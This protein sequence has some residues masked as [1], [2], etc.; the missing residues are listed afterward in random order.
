MSDRR[1]PDFS[2]RNFWGWGLT[3]EI[4]APDHIAGLTDTVAGR[5]GVPIER[6]Q[7]R[8]PP[9]LADIRLAKPKISPPPAL[10]DCLTADAH[11]RAGHCYGKSFRDVIRALDRRFDCAPDLVAVP[12]DEGQLQEILH[13]CESGDIAVI[14][15]GGGSSVS[16]GVEAR[17][18]TTDY[19]GVVS[20]DLRCLDRVLEVDTHSRTA[21]IQGGI[22]GPALEEVLRPQGLT[23][24]HYP[25]SFE[26]STL[27]GW[28]ATRS[29]GHYATR[30]THIDEFVQ[31][32]RMVSPAGVVQTRRLPGSGAG[33]DPNRF[34]I[35][36][37][38]TAGIITEA[39]MRL[40]HRPDSR[41]SSVISF[42][43]EQAAVEACRL[44]SQSGLEPANLRLI[45]A[46]E[47]RNTGVNDGSAHCL[48]LGFEGKQRNLA[49]LLAEGL[50]I[51][52]AQGG[53]FSPPKQGNKQAKRPESADV[54]R[55]AFIRAP[56]G[57][58][59]LACHGLIVETF[60]TAVTWDQFPA[61]HAALGEALSEAAAAHC[62][63]LE[64]SWRYTHVYPDGPAPYYTVTALGRAGGDRLEQWDSIKQAVSDV[65]MRCGATITHHHAVG[66]DHQPWHRSERDSLLRQ[67]SLAALR[68]LDP[69]GIMNP[70]ALW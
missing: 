56:Y 33:S 58:D 19:K 1:G 20:L 32:V 67:S 10:A 11:E 57:R 70:G 65:L 40:Q 22:Y 29:G 38:G 31:S 28:I 15:F 8:P 52:A 36:S 68:Q 47:A 46:I 4:L 66:R 62:E 9:Q 53:H 16:G 25:Q 63:A 48:I 39:W 27:G 21:R 64:W 37:E 61:M 51:C 43:E 5:L 2:R 50:D 13:W 41:A 30:Y 49:P 12:S 42:A 60:E 35:G 34:V 3:E 55:S 69:K 18:P 54:W 59:L 45:N 14:P 26:Y 23:M 7:Y 24:R 6:L 44:L 17:L